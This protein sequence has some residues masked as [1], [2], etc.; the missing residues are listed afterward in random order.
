MRRIFVNLLFVV[1]WT[2][3]ALLLL[4]AGTLVCG[5]QILSPDKL[6][7]IVSKFAGK[8]VDADVQIGRVELAFEPSFP[9]LRLKVDSL[10]VISNALQSSDR[11]ALPEYADT[12]LTLDSFFGDVD[13]APL[14]S[15]GEIA[16]GDVV[17]TR[18]AM[19]IVFDR[20]GRA[21]FDI[22]NAAV[23]SIEGDATATTAIPP[24]CIRRIAFEEPG[25]IRYF[26][27]ADS[28]EATIVLLSEATLDGLDQP[29]YSL[30]V[31]GAL[32]GPYA[33]MMNRDNFSFGVDGRIRWTPENYSTL[34]FEDFILYGDFLK[35]TV[36]AEIA[37][38]DNA[39]TLSSAAVHVEPFALVDAL[40][41]APAEMMK[42]YHLNAPTFRTNAKLAFD[43]VLDRPFTLATDSIPYARLD[44]KVPA[45]YVSYGKA[46]FRRVEFDGSLM[47]H[48][49]DLDSA[50]IDIRKF[51]VAGPA[52]LL[53]ISGTVSRLM[54]DP[55]FKLAL[56]G[57]MN[58]SLFPPVLAQYIPGKL[59][60]ILNFD[61]SAS[62]RT[63]MFNMANFHNLDVHGQLKGSDVY[64]CSPDTLQVAELDGINIKFGS[65]LRRPDDKESAPTLAAGIRIDTASVLAD[66]VRMTGGGFVLGAGVENT[67]LPADSMQIVPIGG[68]VKI[69][70]LMI[71][72]IAD[73]AR[74]RMRNLKGYAGVHRYYNNG[75]LPLITAQLELGSVFAGTADTR[76]TLRD[77][78]LHISTHK[79]LER[80]KRNAELKRIA[81]SIKVANPELQ[82]DSVFRLAMQVR[83]SSA[84]MGRS[85][86]NRRRMTVDNEN[87]VIDWGVSRGI[88]RFLLDW[89][90]E[91]EL[92]TS[93]ARLMTPYFPLRNRIN[94]LNMFFNTDSV[95]LYGVRCNLGNTDLAVNG[96]V[97]NIK[98]ALTSRRGDNRLKLEFLI[99]SDT[100]DINQLA[101]ATFAGAAYVE[102]L[103]SGHEAIMMT[104]DENAM[105]KHLDAMVAEDVDS[106]A[107][108][109]VPT[110]V[111]GNLEIVAKTV[112]YDEFTFNNFY[113][114]LMLY[115]G[116]V[117]LH[118]IS[119]TSDAGN[120]MLTALYSAPKKS[121]I[122]FGLGLQLER[123]KIDRFLHLVP[124]VDSIMPMVRDFSGIIDAE[125]A[126]TVDVDS[127]MNMVLPTL[128]AVVQLSGDSLAFINAETYATLGKWL[129]FR[130]RA[131]NKIK[132]ASAEMLIR[133]NVLHLFPFSF[134]IDRYRLGILGYNDL[135]MNFNYHIS[136][137]K[138]PLP[139]KFGIT[140][141][142]NAD[143]YKI[144]FG[145]AKFKD[146]MIAESVSVVDTARVNLVQQIENVF[147]RGVQNSKLSKMNV[148]RPNSHSALAAPDAELSATDSLALIKEGI[149]EA[150]PVSEPEE[151]KK[152]GVKDKIKGLFGKKNTDNNTAT[153]K[154]GDDDSQ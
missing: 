143:D 112:L 14:L 45:S 38:A 133:D 63:S 144:R 94:R 108:I 48:G 99:E 90:L 146:N 104:D 137:L 6:T 62:G 91:G 67:G 126:A 22:Y 10:V 50:A 89:E 31:D 103:N 86:S 97:H 11:A 109:L 136:V 36:D 46:D 79:N 75:N 152:Q 24:F 77:A 121:E 142:G 110:N 92:S 118:D 150:P 66:G 113:S 153:R 147:R 132:H 151:P 81:D 87:E 148:E 58:L 23:D 119:A 114:D 71:H 35:A 76:F 141:K 42:E 128:D 129:R 78:E 40:S 12:L 135:A 73:S 95:V 20:E 5:V 96:M 44:M 93:R 98:R 149:L 18:P 72:S 85:G 34:A 19:N 16:L 7:P 49:N 28:S 56:D 106:M 125:I 101:D 111:Q 124:A 60:G 138:S 26:N 134:D 123:F 37:Y 70:N 55:K 51:E 65:K 80:A 131:D 15:D 115:D 8:M 29:R 154:E 39:L 130:N 21:N 52:T 139:F 116:A 64:F 53:D 43:F 145:G 122:Q 68:G 120:V 27:E 57:N 32:G 41:F 2:L 59:S 47:L 1:L 84:P 88:R 4:V 9:V 127:A 140:V 3:M 100:I 30:E 74:L 117:N 61:L 69:A 105:E 107:A 13:L 54:S 25:A 33:D 83:R 102:R 17:F 82:P